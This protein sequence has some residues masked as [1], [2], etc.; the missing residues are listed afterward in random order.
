MTMRPRQ[1]KDRAYYWAV[2]KQDGLPPC[3]KEQR[4]DIV[5]ACRFDSEL[6]EDTWFCKCGSGIFYTLSDIERIICE[7]PKP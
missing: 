1:F 2:F 6:P 3:T 5:Q 4:T 7:I